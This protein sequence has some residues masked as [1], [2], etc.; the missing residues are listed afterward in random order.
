M[1]APDQRPLDDP[2]VAVDGT[3]MPLSELVAR[4]E[5][6]ARDLEE[7]RHIKRGL[8]RNASPAAFVGPNSPP[9]LLQQVSN[10]TVPLAQS[11]TLYDA[12]SQT[13]VPAE[14][15]GANS[16]DPD[17]VPNAVTKL[18]D[19]LAK[20]FPRKPGAATPPPPRGGALPY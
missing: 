19:F 10:K 11:Q 20:T 17:A 12:L 2:F 13:H 5:H 7:A 18:L 3:S 6:L 15:A 16:S 1:S 4:Y 14:L 9:F 8:V